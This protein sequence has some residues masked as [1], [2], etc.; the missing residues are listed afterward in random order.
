MP[1][2]AAPAVSI[3]SGAFQQR[4]PA[5]RNLPPARKVPGKVRLV[6]DLLRV[7]RWPIDADGRGNVQFWDVTAATLA[8]VAKVF[9]RQKA[10]GQTRPLQWGH[11]DPSTGHAN[12]DAR[13][14]VDYWDALFVDGSTLYGVVYV[15]EAD[16]EDLTSVQRPISVAVDYRGNVMTPGSVTPVKNALIHVAIVDQGAMPGQGPFVQM[17]AKLENV[18]TMEEMFRVAGF[19]KPGQARR[20]ARNVARGRKPD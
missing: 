19:Q 12:A 1:T 17:G 7:G 6:K 9:A 14:V 10:E 3:P 11:V 18:S 16:A 13:D 4:P 15:T 8:D 20:M 5:L 2:A